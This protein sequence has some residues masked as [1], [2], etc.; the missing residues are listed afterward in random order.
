MTM[1][2][3]LIEAVLKA[4]LLLAA[5]GLLVFAMR[6]APA[7]LRHFIWS[8]S[9]IAALAVP[10][11]T[12]VLPRWQLGIVSPP[13]AQSAISP[14]FTVPNA[15]RLADRAVDLTN[16]VE[17]TTAA[18]D[19]PASA[20]LSQRVPTGKPHDWTTTLVLLW[21]GGVAVGIIHACRRSH[22]AEAAR[23][24][25]TRADRCKLGRARQ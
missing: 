17:G 11:L 14:R 21:L 2:S 10:A 7:S 15:P 3:L 25:F 6:N 13:G 5:A 16:P 12:L 9:L 1:L 22:V 4:T 23:A 18:T 20:V 24:T 8:C 19:L